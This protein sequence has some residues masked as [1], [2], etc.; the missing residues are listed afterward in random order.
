MIHGAGGSP[1]QPAPELNGE[2]LVA[3]CGLPEWP[4]NGTIPTVP[5]RVRPR[6]LPFP[7]TDQRRSFGCRT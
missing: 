6:G 2:M 1:Q 3:A 7:G 4:R 5:A